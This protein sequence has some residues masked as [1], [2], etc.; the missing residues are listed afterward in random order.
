[1]RGNGRRAGRA[2]RVPVAC[3][4][5]RRTPGYI[6]RYI[7]GHGRPGA[8][9][10]SDRGMR[11][12]PGRPAG[13]GE[14]RLRLTDLMTARV[15]T[16]VTALLTATSS[17]GPPSDSDPSPHASHVHVTPFDE[18]AAPRHLQGRSPVSQG[19][20]ERWLTGTDGGRL[21]QNTRSALSGVYAGQSWFPLVSSG[22]PGR[23]RTC[24]TRFKNGYAA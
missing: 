22:A 20:R 24:D 21:W 14:H 7:N 3:P 23:N 6:N 10:D 1:V 4:S 12:D 13:S 16:P 9:S 17:N 11:P 5:K 2:P 19:F 15:V 8:S 18:E